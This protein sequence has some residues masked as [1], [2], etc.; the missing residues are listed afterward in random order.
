MEIIEVDLDVE[1]EAEGEEGILGMVVDHHGMKAIEMM[2]QVVEGL[3][4][5]GTEGIL[6]V[7][8]EEAE[9]A[10]G[11]VTLI[12]TTTLGQEMVAAG[13][14]AGEMVAAGALAGE[15]VVAGALAGEMVAA[16]VTG[17]GTTTMKESP[18]VKVV[19]GLS[20]PT[21]M[22][23]KLSRKASPAGKY[24]TPL[25]EMIRQERVMQTTPGVRTDHLHLSWVSQV[26]MLT[27]QA[28]GVLPVE[29]LAAEVL[30]ERATRITG[31]HRED[32]PKRS[33]HGVVGQKLLPRKR[34][35][36]G[37]KVARGAGAKEGVVAV[38][39]I[40]RQMVHNV[41]KGTDTGS[42]GW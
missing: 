12:K 21:G 16:V 29:E 36:H 37:A 5:Y 9:V 14:L 3:E 31:T 15:M 20:L 10:L 42:G 1:I 40:K 18:W 19:A 30:G 22:P 7:A 11:E 27:S 24:K 35:I 13:A 4:S 25:V 34:S 32:Q 2:N 41:N 17:T 23:T 26:V 8:E 39:G 6:M 33:L 38:P 28:L